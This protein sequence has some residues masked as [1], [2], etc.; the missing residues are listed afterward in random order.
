MIPSSLLP[1]DLGRLDQGGSHV[2]ETAG[3][4]EPW[5]IARIITRTFDGRREFYG[6]CRDHDWLSLPAFYVQDIPHCPVCSDPGFRR[7]AAARAA[8]LL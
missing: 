5:L 1:E 2:R 7:F 8:G 3:E 4:F 6:L